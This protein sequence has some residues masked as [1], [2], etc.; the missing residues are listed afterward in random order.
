MA[1]SRTRNHVALSLLL[2]VP[3]GFLFKFWPWPGQWWFRDYGAGVLYE[4][5]WILVVYLAAPRKERIGGIALWVFIATGILEFL[6]L[7]HPPFLETIRSYFPGR[8]LI[9]TSF[10]WWDFPHY[11][12]GCAIGWV[13]LRR[14][15]RD[16]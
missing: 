16:Q 3:A 2:V 12:A 8:A 5:F 11:G 1:T 15:S 13:W 6:Q 9:G 14:L 7:W 10:S 4:V